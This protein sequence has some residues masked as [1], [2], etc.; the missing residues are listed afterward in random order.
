MGPGRAMKKDKACL[1]EHERSRVGAAYPN[2]QQESKQTAGN[3]TRAGERVPQPEALLWLGGAGLEALRVAVSM[4][5]SSRARA[6]RFLAERT[7]RLHSF[8][9]G[10]PLCA[11]SGRGRRA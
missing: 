5:G 11:P 4:S 7:E 3:E 2:R 6:R 8:I 10:E 1:P 9:G